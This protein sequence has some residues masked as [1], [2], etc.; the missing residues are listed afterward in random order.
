MFQ[1]EPKLDWKT[2]VKFVQKYRKQFNHRK[3]VE[4]VMCI[5]I[6]PKEDVIKIKNFPPVKYSENQG[7]HG[8]FLKKIGNCFEKAFI[9]ISFI[10]KFGSQ[11]I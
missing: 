1:I 5:Q 3:T 9:I 11:K 10:Q 4:N 6:N 2:N 8:I 7:K